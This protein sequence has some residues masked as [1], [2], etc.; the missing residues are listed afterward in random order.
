MHPAA[1]VVRKVILA[2]LACAI[3]A[4]ILLVATTET[5]RSI[6]HD[7]HRHARLARQWV[8][9]RPLLAPL[10]FIG[11]Y[12]C[13]AVLALPVW[14]LQVLAGYGFGLGMGIVWSVLGATTGAT[15]VVALS[16][17]L[18]RDWTEEHHAANPSP[19]RQRIQ[20]ISDK[21]GHNGLMV[22]IVV[23]V[24][25]FL[26]FALCNYAL[27]LT[28]ISILDVFVGTLLGA[29]PGVLTYVTIGAAR[30]LIGDW[31]LVTAIVAINALLML[32]LALRY[33]R[34]EWFRKIGIE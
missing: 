9:D 18:T 32:P 29:V 26:P 28:R 34:P 2:L 6:V 16:R 12:L 33:W 14:W 25:H 3:A 19:A 7:P 4:A 30:E 13:C 22:V 17:W 23:R 24:A 15:A 5:G 10:L 1:P 21:L 31:R 20:A 27:G 8:T 11:L